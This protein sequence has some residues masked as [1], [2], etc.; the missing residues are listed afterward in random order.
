VFR[1]QVRVY[2]VGNLIPIESHYSIPVSIR[3]YLTQLVLGR[4]KKKWI[5][6]P[7]LS[8]FF[9]VQFIL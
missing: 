8:V 3:K 9:K 4:E 1:V 2:E 5:K 6:Q 7:P